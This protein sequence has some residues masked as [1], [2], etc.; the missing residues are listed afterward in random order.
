MR[1][2]EAASLDDE[3]LK[4]IVRESPTESAIVIVD[5][6]AYRNPDL[7]PAHEE[8]LARSPDEEDVWA[9]HL[10]AAAVE[11]LAVI[12]D[13]HKYVALLSGRPPPV[14]QDVLDNLLSVEN[15]F[16]LSGELDSENVRA[17]RAIAAELTRLVDA[18]ETGK[19]LQTVAS[20]SADQDGN[21]PF[22]RI[23][24]YHRAGLHGAVIQEIEALESLN[25]LSP[26]G[27]L[28]MAEAA[29]DAGA[30]PIA[31]RLIAQGFPDLTDLEDLETALKLADRIDEKK[32]AAA[33]ADRLSTFHPRS[34]GLLV[35]RVERRI[36]EGRYDEAAAHLKGRT[37]TETSLAVLTFL[38]ENLPR[39]GVP[40]YVAILDHLA[41]KEVPWS[42]E[43]AADLVQDALRRALPSH[44][45]VVGLASKALGTKP[46]VRAR[47][48]CDALAALLLRDETRGTGSEEHE[49]LTAAVV[50]VVRFLAAHPDDGWIRTRLSGLLSSE[51]SGVFGLAVAA[52]AAVRLSAEPLELAPPEERT[53]LGVPEKVIDRFVAEA[54]SWL[55]S[56]SPF[57]LGRLR[58]PEKI[59]PPAP[60]DVMAFLRNLLRRL[61]T[62]IAD[63][64]DVRAL[65]QCLAVALALAPHTSQP[66]VDQDLIRIAGA[67]L[68]RAG[69]HQAARDLAEQALQSANGPVRSRIAWSIAADL[70]QRSGG[71]L[72]ALLFSACAAA[73]DPRVE[74]EQ[75][76][77]EANALVRILRDLGLYGEARRVHQVA[78]QR[79]E[80]AGL[81]EVNRHR[82][83]VMK[84]TLDAQAVLRHSEAPTDL[85]SDLLR[86]LTEL[87]REAIDQ[88]D[89]LAPIAITLANVLAEASSASISV[90]EETSAVNAELGSRLVGPAA[91][92][93]RGIAAPNP[94]TTDLLDL[95][96][97]T[98]GTRY[99]DDAPHDARQVAVVA[100]RVLGTCVEQ[101]DTASAAFCIELVADRGVA[102]PGWET[103]ARPAPSL[104]SVPEA[105]QIAESISTGG[106]AVMLAAMDSFGK[107]VAVQVRDGQAHPPRE[108]GGETFSTEALEG[109]AKDYPRRYGLDDSTPNL[110]Y[111]STEGLGLPPLAPGPVTLVTDV[112]LQQVPP[113]VFREGEHLAGEVRPMAAAPSLSWLRA[114]RGWRPG[115]EA[116]RV[117]WIPLGDDPG[118]TLAFVA[119]R[120]EAEF[121]E[122]GIELDI[123][124][125]LPHGMS[126]AGLAIVVAHGGVGTEERFFR[127]VS[128]EGSLRV[129]AGDLADA[130]RN[131]GIVILF[132]CHGGRVDRAPGVNTV[133]GLAKKLLDRGCSCVIAS[134]WPLNADVPHRWLPAFL[135]AME[136]GESAIVANFEAN[137][138]VRATFGGDL[139]RGLA[140]N[141]YGDP[142]RTLPGYG[143]APAASA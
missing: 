47:L 19:A 85:L 125:E 36:E 84:V 53:P 29:I 27:R 35:H 3:R 106:T 70:Y 59:L 122:R 42:A 123:A 51:H 95:L 61:G 92:L 79:L 120:L 44:A 104:T 129:A 93:W 121:E 108:V 81:M 40:D 90:P 91:T 41:T 103:R 96:R 39:E 107:L 18:G 25:D 132:V 97:G 63:E 23:Q 8:H 33:V 56:V 113:N 139:S 138:A 66:N 130:L 133:V 75:A 82:H 20:L 142:L 102:M 15:A 134:P 119:D 58:L 77:L 127:R 80:A 17:R 1:L 60:D 16:V 2:V 136:R 6:A 28:R 110:F 124:A 30:G 105:I 116:R 37:G 49:T 7:R 118:G 115:D 94:G 65:H 76:I 72:D 111:V 88:G 13:D 89:D 135:N 71:N 74:S 45:L 24:I 69:R 26:V 46:R 4:E 5:A 67:A 32:L 140:M 86:R 112:A 141:L 22:F 98:E 128:D 52:A 78:G 55:E 109:W 68:A 100:R 143:P 137:A 9:F 11:L 50:E 83:E 54:W 48:I 14:R 31:R 114:A 62:E 21:K 101:R 12:K 117:A 57:V 64:T 126:D 34:G 43:A 131:V 99:S 73:G 10:R 38:S 87:G